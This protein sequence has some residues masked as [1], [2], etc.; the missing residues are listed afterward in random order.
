MYRAYAWRLG[1]TAPSG[2]FAI[3]AE[4]NVTERQRILE[5]YSRDMSFAKPIRPACLVKPKTAEEIEKVIALANETLRAVVPV[6][7]GPPHFRGDTVPS[8]GGAI[9]VDMS[10]MK[11]I[12]RIDR[13]N[14]VAMVEP[15]V[16]FAELQ[17]QVERAGMRL[18]TP[19]MP[20]RSKSVVG[21]LLEREPVVM[22]G[23]H[24]DAADPLDCVEVVFGT[25]ARFRTGSAS[26]PG[27][28]EEQLA[29]GGAQD[30]PL[31]PGQSSWH[32][33]IQGSQGTLGIVTWATTRC[34][35]LPR[36]EAPFM[37]CSKDLNRM[38]DFVHW[39]VRLRLVNEC[40]LL[41]RNA[42][43]AMTA[44]KWPEDYEEL[45]EELQPWVLFFNIAGYDYFPEERVSYRTRDM[46]A[47]AQ[48]LGLQPVKTSAG[49]SAH[50]LLSLVRSPSPEPYW[51]LRRKGA[52]QDLFFLTTF[53]RVE[54]Q[55]GLV[56]YLCGELGYPTLD[57]GSYLQPVVQGASCHCEFNFFYDLDNQR[58]AER[59]KRLCARATKSLADGGAFFSR[60]YGESA[61]MIMNRDASTVAALKKIKGIFDP[62][63]I[64]NPGKLCF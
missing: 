48:R 9:I 53:D 23:Y 30:E 38:L 51:K 25:G 33:A 47:S 36:L 42:V 10:N 61:R 13:L 44:E 56:H 18:N 43:A 6:S 45:L 4:G 14:R 22:P 7:S 28:I 34:E 59:V 37:V 58:E 54:S 64:M 24:W 62:N 49:V 26:G 41:N 11:R 31:G 15:G 46:R 3:F 52:C 16:T 29:S 32:R 21:S 39:L 57:M 2:L 19:L 40:F 35:L 5:Q 50:K 63:N 8:T 20:R 27:T 12:L 17:P 60:P 55:I 1:M